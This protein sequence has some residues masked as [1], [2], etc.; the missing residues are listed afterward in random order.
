MQAQSPSPN[1][2]CP[3]AAT[4]SNSSMTV[5]WQLGTLPFI[6]P[7]ANG[8]AIDDGVTAEAFQLD[9][10]VYPNP[11]ADYINLQFDFPLEEDIQVQV[12]DAQGRVWATATEVAFA[13]QL[14]VDTQHLPKG[15]YSINIY[16]NEERIAQ[17]QLVKAND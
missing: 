15:I 9:M 10:S 14:L 8:A 6:L 3:A 7:P 2:V 4:Q 12:T 1:A 13:T 5:T 16:A 17:R 11:A